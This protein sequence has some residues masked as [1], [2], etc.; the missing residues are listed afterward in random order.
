MM[1]V[2]MPRWTYAY[3]A[4]KNADKAGLNVQARLLLFN[5]LRKNSLPQGSH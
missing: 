5:V 1:A 2:R 4:Y 3:D